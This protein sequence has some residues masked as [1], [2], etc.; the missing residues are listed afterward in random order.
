MRTGDPVYDAERYYSDL[1]DIARSH[2]VGTCDE[3]GMPVYDEDYAEFEEDKGYRID[4]CILHERCIVSYAR[5]NW[6]IR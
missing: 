5:D 3:C 4:G 2:E 1:E 6:A